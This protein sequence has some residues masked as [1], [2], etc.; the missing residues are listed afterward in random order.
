MYFDAVLDKNMQPIFNGTPEEVAKWLR[1]NQDDS[2]IDKVCAGQSM[3]LV[4]PKDYLRS[5][6]AAEVL[7]LVREAIEVGDPNAHAHEISQ[8]IVDLFGGRQ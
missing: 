4:E 7:D 1:R 5:S 8:K 2:T 6:N 3:R